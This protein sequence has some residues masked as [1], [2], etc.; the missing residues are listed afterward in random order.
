MKINKLWDKIDF[1]IT[2]LL[3]I[4]IVASWYFSLKVNEPFKSLLINLTAG[5]IGS[6][7]TIWGI[8]FL[9]R[10]QFKARWDEAKKTA[11]Q[12]IVELKNMLVSYISNPLGFVVDLYTKDDQDVKQWSEDAIKSMVVD[13]DRQDLGK[14]LNRLSIEQ[15][16]HFKLN[17]PF[18]RSSLFEK[19][20]LYNEVLP[21]EVFGQLLKIKKDCDN[22][23]F[24]FGLVPELF[25]ENESN[26]P[27]N[28]GGLKNNRLI[29]NTLIKTLSGEL[30]IYFK[31]IAT[32]INLLEKI[33]F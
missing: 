27:P 3:V 15:W 16:R 11:K 10:K 9:R 26:W 24:A 2:I 33:E 20:Q 18:I 30:K 32:L 23:Y 29:R 21:P 5:F 22:F 1:I 8:E 28:K 4:F 17:L 31:D 19:L 13:I 6:I 25:T 12:D 14:I 7:I